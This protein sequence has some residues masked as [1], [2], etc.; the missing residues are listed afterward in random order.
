MIRRNPNSSRLQRSDYQSERNKEIAKRTLGDETL[1][2]IASD[3]GIT[4]ERVRQIGFSVTGVSKRA[5]SEARTERKR[6]KRIFDQFS[7]AME[8]ALLND[9]RCRVCGA[10]NI[11]AGRSAYNSG[12][13]EN[14]YCCS[15]ECTVFYGLLRYRLERDEYNMYQATCIIKHQENHT[16]SMIEHARRVKAGVASILP[17]RFY[18][19]EDSKATAALK[20]V[21]RL[22]TVLRTTELFDDDIMTVEIRDPETRNSLHESSN[23]VLS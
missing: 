11:R 17:E 6:T 1:Q 22:R 3:Y 19:W 18:V 12:G 14:Y 7:K 8:V 10:H 4:R 9:L 16:K 5:L 15:T 23:A 20:E 2:A 13:N 21:R